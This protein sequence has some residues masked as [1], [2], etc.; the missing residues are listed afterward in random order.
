MPLWSPHPSCRLNCPAHLTVVG[1]AD[2]DPD[3]AVSCH[4]VVQHR[5]LLK[6][7]EENVAS[8][9]PQSSQ[10]NPSHPTSQRGRGSSSYEADYPG[11]QPP[12]LEPHGPTDADKAREDLFWSVLRSF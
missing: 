11:W 3:D 7:G 2:G 9:T 1:S 5:V 12:L 8:Q 10:S 6:G 4:H